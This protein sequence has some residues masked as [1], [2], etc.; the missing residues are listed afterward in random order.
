[1]VNTKEDII[2]WF[3]RDGK[4]LLNGLLNVIEHG[5]Q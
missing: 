2:E 3:T 1:M 4:P 5:N